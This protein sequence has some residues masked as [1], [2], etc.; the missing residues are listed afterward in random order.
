MELEQNEV[1]QYQYGIV[2]VQNLAN[3]INASSD[4]YP[5]TA[6]SERAAIFRYRLMDLIG[7]VELSPQEKCIELQMALDFCSMQS[8]M[9]K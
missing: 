6:P 2:Q 7:L 4:C 8:E 3:H 1:R 5:E 9:K